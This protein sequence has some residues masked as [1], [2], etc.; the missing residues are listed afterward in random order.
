MNL[1]L[2]QYSLAAVSTLL[3]TQYLFAKMVS[4]KLEQ[5]E[6]IC[7]VLAKDRKTIHIVPT[8]QDINVLASID[9]ALSPLSNLTDMLSEVR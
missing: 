7:T 2:N 3:I 9:R 5:E 4:R 1:G 8:W 6:A